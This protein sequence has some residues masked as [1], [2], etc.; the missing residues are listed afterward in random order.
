MI[1]T[2]EWYGPK[3]LYTK[4]VTD[5]AL[6]MPEC[7]S[8]GVYL[9]LIPINESYRVNYVGE[10]NQ[11]AK[12]L[13]AHIREFMSGRAWLYDIDSLKAE[14]RGHEDLCYDP[15]K[16]KY[17]SMEFLSLGNNYI[18]WVRHFLSTIEILVAPV[19]SDWLKRI[20]SAVIRTVRESGDPASTLLDNYR[21]KPAPSEPINLSCK[22]P[23]SVEGLKNSIYI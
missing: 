20:E 22:W 23:V 6:Y 21:A 14:S 5:S 1:D 13:D 9:W 18:D 17:Q 15:S 3:P 12:R 19:E 2:L 16:H 8:S 4:T 7:E 11:M 10:S